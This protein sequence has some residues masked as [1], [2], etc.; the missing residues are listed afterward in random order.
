MKRAALGLLFLLLKV[1]FAGILIAI[2]YYTPGQGETQ[3]RF[4][5]YVIDIKTGA[6]AAGAMGALILAFY[7]FKF[8]VWLKRLP[9]K[10]KE[11]W[12][13]RRSQRSQDC[14]L[15]SY[16][17]LAA[18]E[19]D[20]AL[21]QATKSKQL[22]Q[23]SPFHDIFEAQA[24]LMQGIFDQAELKFE[25][26][27]QTKR[28]KFLGLRGLV[29]VKKK[30]KRPDEIHWLL[31]E[32]LKER[33]HSVWALKGLLEY[34]LSHLEFDKAMA[35]VDQLR[36]TGSLSK[37]RTNRYHALVNWLQAQQSKKLGDRGEAFETQALHSLKL[38]PTLMAATLELA[39]HYAHHG[40]LSKA[41]KLLERGY[42]RQPHIDYLPVF[43]SLFLSESALDQYR[44]I[45]DMLS[46]QS[47]HRVSRLILANFAIAAKL[48]GQA[49]LHL[50]LLKDHPTQ[51]VYSLLADLEQAEH[52]QNTQAVSDYLNSALQAVPEGRWACQT[53]H[54]QHSTWTALCPSC[55]AF[56]QIV[57]EI[58]NIRNT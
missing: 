4:I 29:A 32:A 6:L 47:T 55:Q 56:D 11:H 21:D 3:L 28:T 26:L 23:N 17:A 35:V 15:E 2:S 53:C 30:Q 18:E 19:F 1:L 39:Q 10:F 25:H 54:T 48:W 46:K 57:W 14:L 9:Q 7:T 41:V 44:L 8:M 27:R 45:E 42:E 51:L 16:I 49:R 58:G 50:N 13:E 24:L 12:L 52:P 31:V 40:H 43:R 37:P 22:D 38:D 36:L 20:T 34:H 5:D 33:P